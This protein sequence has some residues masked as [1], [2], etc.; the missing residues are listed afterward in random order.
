MNNVYLLLGSNVEKEKNIG[1][2][3]EALMNCCGV[4]AVSPLYETVPVLLLE[5]PTFFNIVVLLET[6]LTPNEIKC[7]IIDEIEHGLRRKRQANKNAR[8]T[9][10]IDIVLFNEEVMEYAGKDGRLHHLPDPDL[11]KFAHVTV[12]LADLAPDMR[13]P[14]TGEPFRDLAARLWQE[15][16]KDA[17]Q[18]RTDIALPMPATVQPVR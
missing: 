4:T 12:P 17:L 10:D 6:T 2:A 8:R 5:Q 15:A 7:G 9:I 18:I 16:G 13:H 1:E 3:I 11:L 14:E